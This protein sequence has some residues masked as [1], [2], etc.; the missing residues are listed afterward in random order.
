MSTSAAVLGPFAPRL[1]YIC[2]VCSGSYRCD[3]RPERACSLKIV[4]G[5]SPVGDDAWRALFR[6]PRSLGLEDTGESGKMLILQPIVA[7]GLRRRGVRD[8]RVPDPDSSFR[9]NWRFAACRCT[10]WGYVG[11]N[12]ASKK[13]NLERQGQESWTSR[14]TLPWPD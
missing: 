5:T 7:A 10:T 9:R 13:E 4:D 8:A 1:Q 6:Y 14:P 11:L 12:F 3:V 2:S